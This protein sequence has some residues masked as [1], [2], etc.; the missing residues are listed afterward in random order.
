MQKTDEQS[1]KPKKK[2]KNASS[3]KNFHPC[4]IQKK[5]QKCQKAKWGKETKT[6]RIRER[7]K[8]IQETKMKKTMTMQKKKK[9]NENPENT[10]HEKKKKS[11]QQQLSK[12]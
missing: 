11:T 6:I 4:T 8:F 10:F 5:N 9:N 12:A 3:S 7:K 2:K 1:Q